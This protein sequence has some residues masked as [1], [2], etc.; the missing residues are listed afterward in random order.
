MP[1]LDKT[2]PLGQGSLTG[3]KMGR[4]IPGDETHVEDIPRVR[5]LGRGLANRFGWGPGGGRG[6]GRKLRAGAAWDTPAEGRS[7]APR[8]GQRGW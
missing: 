6:R 1:G 3:K 5:G 8:R 2:G 4:C 7:A